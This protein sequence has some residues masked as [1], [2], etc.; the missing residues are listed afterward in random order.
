[1]KRVFFLLIVIA[2]KSI[3]L[4]PERPAYTHSDDT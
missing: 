4:R 2:F 3:G 1:M